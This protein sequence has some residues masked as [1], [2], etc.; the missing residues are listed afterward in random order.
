MIGP[1]TFRFI[2]A[3]IVVVYHA[4]GYIAIGHMAVYAFFILSG[5]WI[6]RMYTESYQFVSRPYL[7]FMT[8]RMLRLYPVYLTSI[9]LFLFVWLIFYF[10]S[11]PDSGYRFLYGPVL[12][13]EF[14]LRNLSLLFFDPYDNKL[15][16]PAWSLDFEVQFY[17]L[18]PVFLWIHRKWKAVVPLFLISLVLFL[19]LYYSG[20]TGM[21]RLALYLPFFFIGMILYLNRILTVSSVWYWGSLLVFWLVFLLPY[22]IPD[23]YQ[24][25]IVKRNFSFAGLNATE[26]Y[27]VLLALLL[28]PFIVR[29]LHR[30]SG[31]TDRQLG[32]L[33]YLIYLFHWIFLIPYG[34]VF[35]NPGMVK[36]FGY[37]LYIFATL[38]VSVLFLF[39]VDAPAEKFRKSWLKSKGYK[40]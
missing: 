40:S 18:A 8:S 12:T 5:Y 31:K 9:A 2:L 26:V 23:L 37:S 36:V 1:G 19:V 6:S 21:L 3:F 15:I 7:T 32:N 13:G 17:L 20:L 4:T 25:L 33:S 24:T 27:N 29:N 10:F 28:T 38:S 39:L 11:L 14:W 30:P 16:G 34:S 35:Q 22:P